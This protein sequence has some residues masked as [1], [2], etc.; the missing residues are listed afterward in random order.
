MRAK[1]AWRPCPRVRSGCWKDIDARFSQHCQVAG[2]ID[3]ITSTCIAG[4]TNLCQNFKFGVSKSKTHCTRWCCCF[5][6]LN[7]I[8]LERARGYRRMHN[9]YV[10]QANM[11]NPRRS[12]SGPLEGYDS[13]ETP[14][15]NGCWI[16]PERGKPLFSLQKNG[17]LDARQVSCLLVERPEKQPSAQVHSAT[18]AFWDTRADGASTICWE[19]DTMAC[20]ILLFGVAI[21][22]TPKLPTDQAR[23]L[24]RTRSAGALQGVQSYFFPCCIVFFLS[25][26]TEPNERID[27]WT[28]GNSHKTT[29]FSTTSNIKHAASHP[30]VDCYPWHPRKSI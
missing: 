29:R 22:A 7:S 26:L 4:L 8:F 28:S 3:S 10:A 15:Y 12:S 2:W 11:L 19:N 23:I 27:V 1:G 6:C 18:A 20:V 25:C 13:T 17:M 30:G 9:R 24:D 16:S 14:K 21:W 5:L